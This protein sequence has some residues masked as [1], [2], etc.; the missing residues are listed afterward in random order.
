MKGITLGRRENMLAAIIHDIAAAMRRTNPSYGLRETID[1]VM[2]GMGVARCAT[3]EN[4]TYEKP[5][6][7]AIAVSAMLSRVVDVYEGTGAA[8]SLDEI[9]TRIESLKERACVLDGHEPINPVEMVM[10]LWHSYSD[11]DPPTKEFNP[12]K[13]RLAMIN[14]CIHARKLQQHIQDEDK[15]GELYGPEVAIGAFVCANVSAYTAACEEVGTKPF[16]FNEETIANT[17]PPM[18]WTPNVLH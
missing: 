11:Y 14:L 1:I 16:E 7:R 3:G 4:L 8:T 10:A 2:H 9:V 15:N 5:E 6:N 18:W 12:A 17:A 13:A